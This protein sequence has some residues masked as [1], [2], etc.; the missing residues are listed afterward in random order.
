MTAQ[1]KVKKAPLIAVGLVIVGLV[2]LVYARN[3]GLLNPSSAG[4]SAVPVAVSLP[5]LSTV[6]KTSAIPATRMPSADQVVVSSPEIRFQEMAWQAQTGLNFANGSTRT[7]QGSLMQKHGVNLR[8]LWEDDVMKQ[9]T[10]LVNFAESFKKGNPHPTEGAHFMS[11]MGDG[12]AATIGSILKD[13][14]GLGLHPEIIGSSGYSRGEDQLMGPPSWKTSPKLARGGLNPDGSGGLISGFLRDGDWNIALKWAGDNGI[15][16]NPDEKTWDPDALNWY[17]ADDYIKAADAYINGVCEDR[18][19]V[20]NG[21]RTGETKHVCVNAVVTWTP[22]DVNVATKKGGLATIVSTKEYRSQMPNTIIGIREWD[23][24]N[25]ALVVEFLAAMFGGGDQVKTFPQALTR[26]CGANSAI[27]GNQQPASYWETYF[28]GVTK[29]DIQGVEVS[30][31]GSSVNNLQDNLALYGMLPGSANVFAATYTVFADVVKQQY[32]SMVPTMLPVDQVLNT[33]YVAAVLAKYGSQSSA[34]PDMPKFQGSQEIKHV[35]SKK[36]WQIN[37]ET[38]KATFTAG[39][40]SQL[41]ELK[42][43]LLIAGDLAIEIHGHTDNTGSAETNRSLSQARAAAVKSW[44]NQQSS[45]DFNQDRFS[46]VQGHGPDM[47]VA[48]NA[49]D[50]G[51]AKR[52]RVVVVLGTY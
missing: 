4:S 9:G 36:A 28:K 47:P 49:T 24:A 51:R 23:R 40:M 29:T 1:F 16:N 13:L 25:K 45:T 46:V 50:T 8:L 33:E 31:G 11:V 15:K 48:T 19:V 42:M 14:Q 21:K 26:A 32:P 38:G 43:G 20:V 34:V 12:S 5:E 27:W 41:N 17:S 52:R 30:L 7:T 35:V 44:L 10:N 2:G 3:H 37:F 39:T 6:A 22:G 18:P